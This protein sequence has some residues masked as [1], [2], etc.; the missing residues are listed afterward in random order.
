MH[1]L[2]LSV[3][4][5]FL[6]GS[7][8]SRKVPQLKVT[9]RYQSTDRLFGKAAHVVILAPHINTVCLW[10]CCPWAMTKPVCIRMQNITKEA[11]DHSDHPNRS[12]GRA[13]ANTG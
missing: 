2:C 6:R 1:V 12:P 3:I 4:G 8:F 10:V 9:V 5:G 7:V 11:H 13:T